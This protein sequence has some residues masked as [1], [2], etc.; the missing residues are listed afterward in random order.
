MKNARQLA[1]LVT[2][3]P[4]MLAATAINATEGVSPGAA[5]RIADDSRAVAR[6]SAG[7]RWMALRSTRSWP[8][9][10][11]RTRRLLSF[12]R[13]SFRRPM[14]CS[15]PGWSGAALPGLPNSSGV[16]PP[17]AAMSGS[18]GRCSTRKV[19]LRPASGRRGSSSRW[20]RRPRPRRCGRRSAC[21]SGTWR[22]GAVVA[23]RSWPRSFRERNRYRKRDRD[24]DRGRI[25]PE[26][27]ERTSWPA[28]RCRARRPSGVSR[29]DPTGETYGVYGI[30][31]S[32]TDGSLGVVGEA[33]AATGEV[34]GVGG[35]TASV[36]GAGVIAFNA[37]DGPDLQLGAAT[38]PAAR[39]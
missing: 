15:T 8:I 7:G 1:A 25:A 29:P 37:A 2:I 9:G 32:S 12:G 10:F 16:S 3:A 6:P 26:A 19:S 36:E 22:M 34:Y 21:C 24:R 14:R 18:C 31:N 4:I 13:S 11:R 20:L 39:G 35:I 33:T 30:T 5:D 23:T 17:A 38:R 27:P 28:R